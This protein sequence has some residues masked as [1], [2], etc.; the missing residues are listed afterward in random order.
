MK[1]ILQH[2]L[3]SFAAF[4]ITAT[5]AQASPPLEQVSTQHF[6]PLDE[7]P[8]G[9]GKS[10]WVSICTAYEAGRHAFRAIEGK[11][12]HWQACNPRQ[13]WTT[14][15]DQRGFEATPQ[16]GDWIWGLELQSYGFGDQQ[17]AIRG[18]PVVE[19]SGQRLS[20]QWDGNVQEW[21]INDQRGLEHGFTVAQRPSFLSKSAASLLPSLSFTLTTRG[22]LRPKVSADAQSVTFQDAA[23]STVLNYTGLKVWDADN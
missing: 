23:G 1:P 2:I 17:Q 12:G 15:F 7:T 3:I 22:D 14:T 8:K 9:L 21:F 11:S 20:Y 6:T 18:S 4:L 5:L 19:A 10:D 13:Q 16:N